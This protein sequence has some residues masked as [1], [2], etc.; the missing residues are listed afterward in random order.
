MHEQINR[1]QV[2][3]KVKVF[4]VGDE[5]LL[6]AFKAH[7]TARV[8][9]VLSIDSPTDNIDHPCSIE[10]LHTTAQRLVNESLKPTKSDD[11]V[12]FF[13]QSFLHM[14]FLYI[15]LRNAI[16]WENGPQIITHWKLWLPR[17]IATGSKNYAVECIHLLTN[18]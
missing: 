15:D 14:A 11:P 6:H 18:L 4:S 8:C 2:D 5:F 9:S 7:L 3:K 1:V 10:W 17:F 13:H 16:R 12:Y